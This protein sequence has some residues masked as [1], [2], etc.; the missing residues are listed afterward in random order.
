MLLMSGYNDCI[1][2]V[3]ER[4]GQEPILCYDKNQVL[5]KLM[6]DGMDWEWYEYKVNKDCWFGCWADMPVILYYKNGK[7]GVTLQDEN[8]RKFIDVLDHI[9]EPMVI[10]SKGYDIEM[11]NCGSGEIGKPRGKLGL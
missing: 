5:L 1:V 3:V 11:L 6:K 8:A 7:F 10:M 4:F 2:G 9:Q